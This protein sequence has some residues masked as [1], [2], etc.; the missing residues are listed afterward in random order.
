MEG[1]LLIKKCNVCEGD[2]SSLCFKCMLYFCD[3]CFQIAHKK[4]E[5]NSHAKEKI[6][7]FCP[8]DTKCSIHKIYPNGLFCVDEKSKIIINNNIFSSIMLSFMR[9]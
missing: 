9:F 7:Y 2:A 5:K 3:S 6:D 8:I 4:K 1:N